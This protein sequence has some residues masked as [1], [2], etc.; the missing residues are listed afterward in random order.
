MSQNFSLCQ[1]KIPCVCLEKVRTKFPVFPVPWPPCPGQVHPS[2]AVHAGRY[3]QQAGGTHPTGMHCFS[4]IFT[5]F[6]RNHQEKVQTEGRN[7]N[8]NNLPF[9]QSLHVSLAMF[10]KD[11]RRRLVG[12]ECVQMYNRSPRRVYQK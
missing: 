11:F 3:G 5:P 12:P 8:T 9:C 1:S 10:A 2:G 7:T 6:R 4:Y